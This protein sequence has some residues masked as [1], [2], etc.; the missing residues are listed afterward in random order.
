M[1]VPMRTSVLS[2]SDRSLK[3]AASI[4]REGG[5]IIYPTDTV[6]AL[7][8]DPFNIDAFKRILKIKDRVTKPLPILVSDLRKATRLAYFSKLALNMVKRNWPGPVTLV[9]KKREETPG[10]L[11]SGTNKIGLRIPNSS[12]TLKLIRLCDGFLV[13]TSANVSGEKSP[14]AIEEAMKQLGDKVDLALNGGTCPVGISS[15]VIDVSNLKPKILRVG[16]IPASKLI[17]S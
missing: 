6:Y 5:V 8:C 1:N 9:L 15:T 3:K 10:F 14:L 12:Q 11:C 13:G 4:I 16:A 7:G 2:I 17:V